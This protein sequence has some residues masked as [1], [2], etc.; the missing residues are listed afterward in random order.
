MRAGLKLCCHTTGCGIT[1]GWD[2]QL[3]AR[4]QVCVE[5]RGLSAASSPGHKNYPGVLRTRVKSAECSY[6]SAA[7]SEVGPGVRA[8]AL[9]RC[10][11]RSSCS[12]KPVHEKCNDNEP[13]VSTTLQ[14]PEV[15]TRCRNRRFRHVV[16]SFHVAGTNGGGSKLSC[17]PSCC[18]SMALRDAHAAGAPTPAS[19]VHVGQRSSAFRVYSSLKTANQ[20]RWPYK[21]A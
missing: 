18:L 5:R 20:L 7:C 4:R 11:L 19:G 16:E 14:E 2:R 12:S 9:G 17:R 8:T 10:H 13:K 6:M 15:S 1:E 3:R 21:L